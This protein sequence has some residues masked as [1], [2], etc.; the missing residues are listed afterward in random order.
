[1]A[2]K[3]KQTQSDHHRQ[4]RHGVLQVAYTLTTTGRKGVLQVAYTLTTTGRE[5]MV[6][7][8]WPTICPSQADKQGVL[9]VAL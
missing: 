8:K 4:R 1:M 6:F 2:L 7:Y 9:Q 5:D 3:E